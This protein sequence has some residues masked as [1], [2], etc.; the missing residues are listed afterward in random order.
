M[1]WDFFA[2]VLPN[3]VDFA[4]TSKKNTDEI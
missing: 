1:M 4:K 2:K 3:L